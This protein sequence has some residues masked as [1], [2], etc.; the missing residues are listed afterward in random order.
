[1]VLTIIPVSSFQIKNITK[2]I[3]KILSSDQNVWTKTF[4]GKKR[5]G[6]FCVQQTSDSGY[7]LT[8][9][10][11]SYGAGD[12][13]LWLIKTDVFGNNEWDKTYGGEDWD[14]GESVQQ[15]SDGGYIVVGKTR[16]YNS[17]EDIWLIKTD[18]KG[19]KEW[20]KAFDL[21][22]YE[23]G[24]SIQQTSDGGYILVG[25]I[26]SWG[27]PMAKIAFWLIKTD[28]Y[29]NKQWDK[30]YSGSDDCG[31]RCVRQT[32]DGG[33]II[34]GG[35]NFYGAGMRDLWLIKMDNNGNEE[36]NKTFG[37]KNWEQGQYVQQTSDGG[38][39]IS[40][41]VDQYAGGPNDLWLIK[42]DS[43]G[44]LQWDKTFGGSDDDEAHSV[45]Q[46]S[47][48]GYIIGGF[49]LSYGSG[50][51]DFWLIKTDKDGNEMWNRTFGGTA[52]DEGWIVQQTT[53]NGFIICG[54]TCS[55]GAGSDDM[56]LIK[57]DE[58]GNIDDGN[59]RPN[60]P[61]SPEGPTKIIPGFEYKYKS[62]TIDMDG[63]T[64]SYFFDWD[65]GT[66]SGWIGP[67]N[68]GAIVQSSHVWKNSGDFE[69]RVKCR[70]KYDKESEWSDPLS[71]STPREKLLDN[72][73]F[74]K[75]SEHFPGLFVLYNRFINTFPTLQK[76]LN[77]LGQ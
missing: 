69:V 11:N 70:D 6:C 13:D 67:Y 8:G 25:D 31:G 30:I 48:G 10:T 54:H 40:G 5:D 24:F 33:F 9:Y 1:M 75:L 44:V 53:D 42:T 2:N 60:K 77:R 35:T 61:N 15:T 72:N 12:F 4:G 59:N 32:S 55:Y 58:N 3:D 19:N 66:D 21:G 36:W 34:T 43:N 39:I 29:G 16:M 18:S 27:Y 68:P 22:T 73:L 41:S 57:T 26:F 52:F 76:H 51:F 65:D 47:D 62:S 56:W 50:Y 74:D 20:D 46:T 71:V 37:G 14:Y 64:L 49:T 63:D 17:L 23:Y 7:I 45:Q 38:F 28:Q